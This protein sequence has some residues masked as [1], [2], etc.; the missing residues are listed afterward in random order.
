MKKLLFSLI[1]IVM[2]SFVGEAQTLRAEFLHGKSTQAEI[3]EAFN[4]LSEKDQRD[5][6]L[7]KFDQLLSLN[8]PAEH[9][10]LIQKLRDGVDKGVDKS[11]AS[12]YLANAASLA[13]I[14]PKKDFG[15]MF[16]L[17][18]DY[19]YT[20]SFID[21]KELPS[22]Y[23][24]D[25]ENTDMFARANCSCRWC[26]GYGGSTGSNCTSTSSGCGFLWM[27][28]CNQCIVCLP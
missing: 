8:L 20:G 3:V 15:L 22:S 11:Q 10:E 16:E 23:I 9:K 1:A 17:L 25:L 28:S 14:T 18:Q 7:E 4:K 26:L 2:F 24:T 27:Q 12:E 21:T 19:E 5:L 13:K 6:W